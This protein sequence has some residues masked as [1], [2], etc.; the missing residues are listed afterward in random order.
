MKFRMEQFPE[1]LRI[2]PDLWL[3]KPPFERFQREEEHNVT[4]ARR[5]KSMSTA[6]E[7]WVGIQDWEESKTRTIR[8][9]DIYQSWFV[10]ACLQPGSECHAAATAKV[11]SKS[12]PV[13]TAR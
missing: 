4:H 5:L 8:I 2:R 10:L 13:S 1:P 11:L 12:Q 3:K 9:A 7:E 6:T